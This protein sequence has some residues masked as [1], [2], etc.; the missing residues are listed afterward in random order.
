MICRPVS[1]LVLLA[2]LMSAP[3]A[4]SAQDNSLGAEVTPPSSAVVGL[5]DDESTPAPLADSL[6]PNSAHAAPASAETPAPS[7]ETPVAPVVIEELAE[8][9]E[10]S[11]GDAVELAPPDA[12]EKK[13]LEERLAALATSGLND[14]D[15]KKAT[16]LYQ[17]ALNSFDVATQQVKAAQGFA[18]E[19]SDT[20]EGKDSTASYA[21][22][23][24]K[25]LITYDEVATLPLADIEK[26][27][28]NAESWLAFYRE[29]LAKMIAEPKRRSQRM[30][31]IPKQIAEAQR[32]LKAASESLEDLENEDAADLV[33]AARRAALQWSQIECKATLAALDREQVLYQKSGEWVTVC[34]DYYARYVPYKEKRLAFYREVINRLRE[35]ETQE[36][37]RIA[38][39]A[40]A[41]AVEVNRPKQI[42]ELANGN[43]RLADE[44]TELVAAMTAVRQ[45]LDST[46]ATRASLEAQK[47]SAEQRAEKLSNAAGQLLRDQQAKLP[48]ISDLE[49]D[50]SQREPLLSEVQLRLYSLQDD[51]AELANLDE[52]SD[53]LAA[54]GRDMRAAARVE[55]RKLLE[56]K[57]TT[58]EQL[59]SDLDA[60]S[61]DLSE[62]HSEQANLILLVGDFANFIAE[63]V[64]WIRSCST[65]ARSDIR[66]AAH[67]LTWSLDPHNWRDAGRAILHTHA[68]KPMQCGTAIFGLLALVATHRAARRQLREVGAEAKKRSC[69]RLLP[70]F[71]ALWLTALVALPWPALLAFVG[72]TMDSLSESEFVRALGYATRFMAVC[73]LLLELA[74]H[75][76]RPSG[77]ADAHFDWPQSCLTHLRSRF[78]WITM[79]G[80]PATLWLVGLEIQ[81]EEP[82]WSSSLGR[83]L[84]IGV[85]LLL[86][87]V[88][89]RV[90][91]AANSPFRQLALVSQG[92]WLTP[93]QLA[94]RP[95]IVLLPSA[96]A[97]LALIGYYF[98]AQQAAVRILQSAGMLLAVL[99]LG[100]VTRRWLLVSRRRLAREQAKQRRAQLASVSDDDPGAITTIDVA[101]DAVD[102]AAMSEQT[103]KLVRTFLT[104]TTVVGLVL[105]WGQVLPALRYPAKHLLPGA[106]ELT[107]G[108]LALFVLTLAVTYISV[109]DVPAL[110]EL[111]VLQHL[112]LDSGSRYAATT[113]TRYALTAVGLTTAFHLMGGDWNRIQWLVAAMSVGL[114][115]G[116]Q[117]IFA[118]FVSGII[119]LFE[120]PIR[121]GDVVTIGDKTGVVN[122]IRMRSTTIVDP[123]RK[124]Y[125]VPNKD[126]VTERLLNWT[127]TDFTNR[128]EI[129][130]GVASGTDTDVA[131]QLLL[132]AARE[133][134]H[135]L[136]EPQP[137][138]S[139]EGFA[140]GGLKLALRCFLPN[141]DNRASTIHNLHTVIDRNF[142]AAGIEGAYGDMRIRVTRDTGHGQAQQ[143]PFPFAAKKGDARQGA[144]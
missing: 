140:D 142:R 107:W 1:A 88:W 114:G 116:L 9:E 98:T 27:A 59:I 129:M 22:R 44:R 96:L 134:P 138:A 82:Y 131:C 50:Y 56:V 95:A 42:I 65:P 4:T 77:L 71:H 122:R 20:M 130:V 139:F 68:L 2:A 63:R 3:R 62:L 85:M 74:R 48:N 115:F 41:E 24:A 94:W 58:L 97:V 15:K 102:L 103:Q 66:H 76:C 7:A 14:D 18:N 40:A 11:Q 25:P 17:Q 79:L 113:M 106:V 12:A 125:I 32:T 99:T 64:L 16:E 80:L 69:T 109:R 70:T 121:V 60:Y 38:A 13:S 124:E 101:E 89:H 10:K 133:Q 54:E 51:S 81:A 35:Q 78:R 117:E 83:V 73:L 47:K 144:A 61:T 127:L 26:R 55:V 5:P 67:A 112:P 132:Q 111:V 52:L 75:L 135:V 84:F 57:R 104:I 8:K 29:Q 100:G 53:K 119:L 23:L 19:L 28:A 49:R 126:L 87:A 93:L 108:H 21:A 6:L 123:D 39:A 128:V 30:A 120:R 45:Q 72:W 31:E 86:S 110:L 105:I 141:L 36:Q 92:G 136:A 90:L 43:K 34:R 143:A 137:S 118:N 37:A 46:R 91:L 33:A